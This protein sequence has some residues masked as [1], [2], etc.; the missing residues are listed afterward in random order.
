MDA[1]PEKEHSAA[2]HQLDRLQVTLAGP[3]DLPSV[4][5]VLND[6]AAWLAAKGIN[7]WPSPFPADTVRASINR[8][9]TYLASADG[10]L[11]GTLAVYWD[12]PRFWGP[13]P[14]DAG[15]LHRLA[16]TPWA[17]GIGVSD[18]LLTWAS[19]HIAEAGRDWLRLDCGADNPKIRSYYERLGFQH[20][21][22]VQV[23][24]D[25]AGTDGSPWRASLYERS[26]R[27]V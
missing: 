24:I 16:V 22:D 3:D 5:G 6:A 14:P 2:G 18:H 9:D 15:Y 7:Q 19:K 26:T 12:D 10:R 1:E 8:G 23:T 11:A 27:R 13:R 20:R 4:L 21:G 25:G 17:R